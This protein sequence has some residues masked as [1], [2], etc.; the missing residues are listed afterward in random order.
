ML[1]AKL[2][3]VFCAYMTGVG[4]L[5]RGLIAIMQHPLRQHRLTKTMPHVIDTCLLIS[6]FVMV[7]GWA[8]SPI[9]QPWLLAKLIALFLYIGFG[10]LMLRWGTNGRRRWTGLAGGLLIY[11]Y[12]L[13]AAHSKSIL[14]FSTLF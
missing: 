14:P 6:G 4:F 7:Y 10:L 1:T 8:I 5:L 9:S 11:A 2:I 13:G 3:H 12:I